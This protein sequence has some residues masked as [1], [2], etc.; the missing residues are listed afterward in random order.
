MVNE[1]TTP[2]NIPKP[3]QGEAVGKVQCGSIRVLVCKCFWNHLIEGN[4]KQPVFQFRSCI[5]RLLFEL[6]TFALTLMM[7]HNC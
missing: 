2:T 7:L 3:A 6:E 4:Y 1:T 5:I